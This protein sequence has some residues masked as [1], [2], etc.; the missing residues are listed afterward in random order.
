MVLAASC[1]S[2]PCYAAVEFNTDMEN[3][4]CT[5]SYTENGVKCYV[6]KENYSEQAIIDSIE[7]NPFEC[8]IEYNSIEIEDQDWNKTWVEE[9][10]TPIFINEECVIH[11]PKDQIGENIKYNILINPIMAFGS[12][13]HETTALNL[14][15]KIIYIFK[16]NRHCLLF[17]I[18]LFFIF[19]F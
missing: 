5:V 19:L 11:S 18:Y 15:E 7:Q 16:F 4:I 9:S 3:G 17:L 8:K 14:K 6:L 1:I 13:H 12:G 2:L 10:F